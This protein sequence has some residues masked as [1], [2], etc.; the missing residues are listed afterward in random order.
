MASYDIKRCP[1]CN[2]PYEKNFYS[3]KPKPEEKIRYGSPI[4]VCSFCKK[5][6]IDEDYK[7]IAIE[8]IPNENDY[9]RFQSGTIL[10]TISSFAMAFFSFIFDFQLLPILFVILGIIIIGSDII[11][12]NKRLNHLEKE[13]AASRERLNNPNYALR[14]LQHGYRVPQE[15]L[16]KED[17]EH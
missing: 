1:S 3:G 12:Y 11:S 13:K 8:G 9:K 14:L 6:F 2:Q 16:P 10:Y 15:F 7:E 4:K 5:E 17:T